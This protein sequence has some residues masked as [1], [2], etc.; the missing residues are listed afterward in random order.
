MTPERTWVLVDTIAH[1]EIMVL[2]FQK[3]F[4]IKYFAISIITV[5]GDSF[6]TFYFLI[7]EEGLGLGM[8]FQGFRVHKNH[9]ILIWIIS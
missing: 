4:A 6:N 8:F 3:L 5:K 7:E 9:I 2:N 1:F